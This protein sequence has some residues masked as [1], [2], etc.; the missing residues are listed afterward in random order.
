MEIEFRLGSHIMYFIVHYGYS[1]QIKC[2]CGTTQNALYLHRT[3]HYKCMSIVYNY[4]MMSVCDHTSFDCWLTFVMCKNFQSLLIRL[5]MEF[6][7]HL[8]E[9][10]REKSKKNIHQYQ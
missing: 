5:T 9:G 8:M 10:E 3:L 4:V 7:L 2:V 6:M 1:S